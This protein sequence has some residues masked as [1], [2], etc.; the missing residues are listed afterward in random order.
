MGLSSRS[1]SFGKWL[2]ISGCILFWTQILQAEQVLKSGDYSV[3][4]NAFNSAMLS[5]EV[6]EQYGIERSTS[7][8]VLNIAILKH[9]NTA[10]TALLE[11]DAKNA[12]SQL[13]P[14]DFTKVREGDAIYY[15]ATFDFADKERVKFDIIIIPDGEQ[16]PIKLNFTQQFFV[17]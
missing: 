17:G 2:I 16:K 13:K 8:G 7:L 10:V 1:F 6:A 4:Y 9:P 5:P 3:H 15:I 12:I 14:L 11:G